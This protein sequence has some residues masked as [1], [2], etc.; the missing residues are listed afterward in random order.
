[1]KNNK[2]SVQVLVKYFT[3]SK[4]LGKALRKLFNNKV[5][6]CPLANTRTGR[7]LKGI[8]QVRK[9]SKEKLNFLTFLHRKLFFLL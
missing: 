7:I 9:Q 2:M 8:N 5:K 4:E 1:M 3:P 6:E